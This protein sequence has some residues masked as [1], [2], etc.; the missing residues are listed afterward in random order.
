MA[1]P[2]PKLVLAALIAVAAPLASHAQQV[3]LKAVNAF[4]EGT[5]F[6][7]NFEAF[8]KKVNDEGKGVV[9]INYIGG[10]KALSASEHATA[11][12]SG[13]VDMANTTASYTANLVPE[14]MVLSFA[15]LRMDALRKNGGLEYLNN[16]YQEKG[17]HYLA[18]TAEGIPYHIFTNKKPA[19]PDLTGQKLRIA[20]IFRDFFQTLGASVL[21]TPPGEVYTALD[22]GVV[23]GFGWPL[24]GIFDLN[25]QERVKYRIDPGFYSVEVGV[26]MSAASWKKLTPAQRSFLEKQ[27]AELEAHNLER[28]AKDVEA[29]KARH[30][31]A[32]IQ[33][34]TF[35]AEQSR[36]FLKT[37]SDS[38][39]AGLIKTSPV[40]GP[41]LRQLMTRPD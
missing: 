36:H 23:D 15:S 37:G 1:T 38:A 30:Q 12:R 25:W 3:T 4:Q 8:V 5:Y 13:V 16:L 28:A 26:V 20:S 17:L 14:G 39:W 41:K 18:R 33:P 11:L 9:Q 34:V 40:H 31:A 24:V 6:A 10:P 27:V 29:E 7:R 35:T 19:G 21:Q 32:G 22:R 2:I